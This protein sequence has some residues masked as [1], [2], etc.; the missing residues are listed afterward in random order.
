MSYPAARITRGRS[1]YLPGMTD[2]PADAT[3]PL[4]STITAQLRSGRLMPF[5]GLGTWQARGDNCYRAVRHALDVGYRHVDTA[6]AYGNEADIGR[7]VADGGVPR[8]ELFLTTKLPV[9]RAGEARA[10]LEASLAAL[11]TDY[12]DLWLLHWPPSASSGQDIWELMLEAQRDGLARD[13]GVSNY[14]SDQIDDLVAATGIAPAVN[15]VPWSPM[16]HDAQQLA[17]HRERGVVVEG[18]SPFKRSDLD[19][20]VIIDIA[21]IHGVTPAQ[22]VL[23]WHIDHEIV[24]IPKSVT[25]E[26]IESNAAVFGFRLTSTERDRMD[27][28]SG[29]D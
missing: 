8:D 3:M 1:G 10:T 19:H 23:R 24:V 9:E 18:Y 17:E 4:P 16:T 6:T 2:A 14:A 29:G 12:V 21:R 22:A 5:L 27:A 13:V 25:P 7:A 11:G 20:P 28:L 26:R 15:Q